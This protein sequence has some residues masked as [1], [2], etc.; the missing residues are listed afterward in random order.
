MMC[1]AAFGQNSYNGNLHQQLTEMWVNGAWQNSMRSIYTN[2]ANYQFDHIDGEK[3]DVATSTWLPLSQV[4]Y[5]L[6]LEQNIDI[7][8]QQNWVEE[9]ESYVN[10]LKTQWTYNTDGTKNVVTSQQWDGTQWKNFTRNEYSYQDYDGTPQIIKIVSKSWNDVSNAWD[11]T[12]QQL[13]TND[14][15]G[16]PQQVMTQLYDSVNDGWLEYGRK[17]YTSDINGVESHLLNEVYYSGAWHNSTQID[18][19]YDADYRKTMELFNIWN[20]ATGWGPYMRVTYDHYDTLGIGNVQAASVG[21]SPNPATDRINISSK[22]PLT[23]VSV[24][25]LDGRKYPLRESSKSVDVSALASGIYILVA[26][27]GNGVEKIK[28]TK[29]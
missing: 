26:E 9:S 11:I 15:S 25:G 1:G 17:T 27:T 10:G 22:L 24:Y 18:I 19:T 14:M 13:Y 8:T 21:I 7:V 12:I 3:W 20:D 28:F 4:D 6:T 23:A 16:H 5:E 2:N 29:K